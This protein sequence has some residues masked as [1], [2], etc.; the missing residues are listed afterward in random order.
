[1]TLTRRW[2]FGLAGMALLERPAAGQTTACT[3]KVQPPHVLEAGKWQMSINPT[4]P[5]QQYINE[6]GE[7]QGLNVVL[8]RAM[9]AQMCLE[10][11]FLRMDFPPMIPG[12]RADRFDTI[13][14]GLFWTEERSKLFF[15]VPYAEQAVSV[16]T[17]PDSSLTIRS[18]DDLAGH[19][20]ATETATYPERM[21]RQA[22]AAMVTRG[23]KPIEFH[24]FT[25]AS[26][27]VAALRAGQVDAL[28]TIDE[29]A[30]DVEKRKIGK[31]LLHGLFGSD[32]TFAFRDGTLAAAAA[33]ALTALKADGT[34]DRVFQTFGMTPLVSQRFAIRGPGLS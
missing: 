25:T 16:L 2:L 28:V 11:V 33:D 4:L 32:I 18:F 26:D 24:A 20:V 5:P 13:N 34:Y 3:P 12:L 23:L 15:L 8:A 17:L 9:A 21:A 6:K 22:D 27:S 10:P 7:L 1:M 29:T 31:T 30:R 19:S 14:T